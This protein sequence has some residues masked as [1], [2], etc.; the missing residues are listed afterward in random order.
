[1]PH[2]LGL[3]STPPGTRP[4][5]H[6]CLE[7]GSNRFRLPALWLHPRPAPQ[8]GQAPTERAVRAL[9]GL[10]LCPAACLGTCPSR[11]CTLPPAPTW[12]LTNS[13]QQSHC[14]QKSCRWGLTGLLHMLISHPKYVLRSEP[15]QTHSHRSIFKAVT[16][17]SCGMSP[18]RPATFRECE[19]S[20]SPWWHEPWC[21]C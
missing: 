6:S 10:A 13:A 5:R 7:G 14:Q 21:P 9:S 4:Q 15:T 12:N 18:P 20:E 1:M 17:I 3:S 11:L 8:P 2:L 19:R 16:Q